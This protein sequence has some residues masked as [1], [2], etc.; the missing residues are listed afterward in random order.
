M[1]EPIVSSNAYVLDGQVQAGD[2]SYI[3]F[4]NYP[5]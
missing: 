3:S 2:L 5:S 1:A 4:S